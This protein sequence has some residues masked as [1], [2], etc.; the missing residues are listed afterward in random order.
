M[1]SEACRFFIMFTYN[2]TFVIAPDRENE[3][4]DYLRT[5]LIPVVFNSESPARNPE[6]K[7]VVEIG[8]ESPDPEHG[9][10]IA[11]SVSFVSI[12]AAHSWNDNTLVPALQDFHLRFGSHALFFVTLLQNLEI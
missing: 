11:L 7:K 12:D 8:G 6:L 4:T 5:E 2:V 9:L 10:S 3:L 1:F